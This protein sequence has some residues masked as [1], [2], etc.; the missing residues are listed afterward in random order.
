MDLNLNEGMHVTKKPDRKSH[1]DLAKKTFKEDETLINLS[2]DE[3]VYEKKMKM[4]NFNSNKLD[5]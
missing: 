4:P 1:R 2:G 5:Y 3:S